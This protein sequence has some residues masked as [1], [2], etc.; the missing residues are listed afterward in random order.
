MQVVWSPVAAQDIERIV[1]FIDQDNPV[2]ARAVAKRLYEAA[3]TL[4]AFP[5]RN[6]KSRVSGNYDLIFTDL[7]YII[8][9]RIRADL[10]EIVRVYHS[11]QQWP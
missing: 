2:A 8:V 5:Y 1:E 7:P 9:Y 11:A 4:N 6:R 10:V 3:A